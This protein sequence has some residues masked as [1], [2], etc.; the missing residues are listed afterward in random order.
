[1]AALFADRFA[2]G[3]AHPRRWCSQ[4]MQAM[5]AMHAVQAVLAALHCTAI[6][7]LLSPAQRGQAWR[8]FLQPAAVVAGACGCGVAR[9]VLARAVLARL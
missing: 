6:A 3:A 1:M 8:G 2:C 5:Q 4:A 7:L 9:A